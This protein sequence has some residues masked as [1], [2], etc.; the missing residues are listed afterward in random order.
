MQLSENMVKVL[1]GMLREWE[2]YTRSGVGAYLKKEGKESSPYKVLWSVVEALHRRDLIRV[3]IRTG[4]WTV[5][6]L[7]GL[8]RKVATNLLEWIEDFLKGAD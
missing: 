3:Y 8:G 2:L 1:I 7:T 5:W 6:S 4:G